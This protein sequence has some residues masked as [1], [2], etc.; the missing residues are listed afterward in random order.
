MLMQDFSM[1]ILVEQNTATLCDIGEKIDKQYPNIKFLFEINFS[2]EDYI[3]IKKLFQQDKN[4]KNT[5][6]EHGSLRRY[7]RNYQKYRLP[8]LILIA[9]FIRYE[10]LND[11]N[12]DNFYE[13][14]LK[15][16]ITNANNEVL[17]NEL[18]EEFVDC[19]FK[20]DSN[21]EAEGLFLREHELCRVSLP[22]ENTGT[23]KFLNSFI[24]HSGGICE[25]DLKEYFKII[26]SFS[27]L[28][29]DIRYQDSE[30]AHMFGLY[31]EIDFKINSKKVQ[32]FFNL[33]NSNDTISK[34]VHE[35]ILQSIA[36]FKNDSFSSSLS[37][38][39]PTY[40]KNYLLFIG[41]YGEE[42]E[43]VS[44]NKT[45]FFYEHEQIFFNPKFEDIYSGIKQISFKIDNKF[46]K[47]AKEFDDYGK[48]DFGS[49]KIPI[50]D[51][52]TTFVIEMFIDSSLFKRFNINLFDCD[53][54]IFDTDFNV[55]NIINREIYVSKKD[56]GQNYILVLKNKTINLSPSEKKLNS[57]FLYKITLDRA[58]PPIFVSGKQLE[59]RFSPK[60]LTEIEYIDD[61]KFIYVGE[62]PKFELSEYYQ[63]RFVVKDLLTSAN[64]NFQEFYQYNKPI[65]KF[66]VEI[67]D[68]SY[69]IVFISEFKILKWFNWWHNDKNI[70]F[71]IS[72]HVGTNAA[73]SIDDN[74]YKFDFN[75]NDEVIKFFN[76]QNSNENICIKI[77]PPKIELSLLDSRKNEQKITN[78]NI[79]LEKL[80]D[81]RQIKAKLINFP[82]SIRFDHIEIANERVDDIQ[83]SNNNYY[84]SIGKIKDVISAL[85][86]RSASLVLKSNYYHLTI[87]N[88]LIAV[89]KKESLSDKH[90][91]TITVYDINFLLNQKEN[92]SFAFRGRSYIIDGTCVE[93][94][95][96]FTNEFVFLR[97]Q[98]RTQRNTILRISFDTVQKEGLTINL[99][100]LDYE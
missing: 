48:K 52:D 4:L 36:T 17:G 38:C 30:P 58:S 98:R 63:K 79:R 23:H 80:D 1:N 74:R 31:Q 83:V 44:I 46:Y 40:I 25:K 47:V 59:L 81:F 9:G 70:Q 69:N 51:I 82:T 91:Q 75:N 26:K 3:Y 60:L 5:Y 39:L 18:R 56:E 97:E 62:L 6:F 64:L 15:N 96:G 92:I 2:K 42:L 14:F 21:S 27:Q 86:T 24:F 76:R 84:V 49:I 90:I 85:S 12:H 29:Q 11:E 61:D 72:E 66:N 20:R 8:F 33:L 10:Y 87:V 50:V 35:L 54:M 45:D 55:K 32:K 16:A 88:I 43:K 94:C 7:F 89:K 13:N 100:D 93:S 19:F 67:A 37:L 65:G 71:A 73:R 68:K 77:L 28:C 34:Y 57:Y 99:Q 95:Q 53:F 41:K 78:T 22:L